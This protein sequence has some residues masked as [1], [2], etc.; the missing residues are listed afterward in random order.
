[1]VTT[2]SLSDR[3]NYAHSLWRIPR[4]EHNKFYNLQYRMWKFQLYASENLPQDRYNRYIF[5]GSNTNKNNYYSC[6]EVAI[7]RSL[8]Q[9]CS[10]AVRTSP[11]VA[12][13]YFQHSVRYMQNCTFRVDLLQAQIISF[14]QYKNMVI[15]FNHCSEFIPSPIQ[16]SQVHAKSSRNFQLLRRSSCFGSTASARFLPAGSTKL[17]AR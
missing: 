17:T 11:K 3:N 9:T 16:A 8:F 5:T 2:Y 6:Y 14:V 1:M 12:C 10:Y 13:F 15:Y 4:K 7:C